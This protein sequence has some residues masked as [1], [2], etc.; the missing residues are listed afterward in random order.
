MMAELYR[1]RSCKMSS[2]A[3]ARPPRPTTTA[4]QDAQVQCAARNIAGLLHVLGKSDRSSG[5]VE[6]RIPVQV[7]SRQPQQLVPEADAGLQPVVRQRK[8]A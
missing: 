4:R 1:Q 3:A 2:G 7:I 6:Q 8:R 5:A